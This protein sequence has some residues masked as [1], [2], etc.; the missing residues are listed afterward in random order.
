[1]V[2]LVNDRL[3]A[4]GKPVL[5]F[6]NPFLY[7]PAGK[8]SFTDVTSGSN[9]GCNTNGFSASPGWDPVA[10]LGTPNFDL[11]LSALGLK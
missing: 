10:G 2:A 7:S 9:P 8:A 6:L 4:A 11:L 1:M 5:G 3:I